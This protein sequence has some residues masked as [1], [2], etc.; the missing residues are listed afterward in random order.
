[1]GRSGSWAASHAMNIRKS[2][3]SSL[4]SPTS[5]RRAPSRPAS[6]TS[7]STTSAG[8][9]ARHTRPP[10]SGRRP[11][12]PRRGTRIC[13]MDAVCGR[14]APRVAIRCAFV[15]RVLRS[16]PACVTV[17][18][19]SESTPKGLSSRGRRSP[20]AWPRV[21]SLLA[22]AMARGLM[23]ADPDLGRFRA[24]GTLPSRWTFGRFDRR[25][26]ARTVP[27]TDEVVSRHVHPRPPPLLPIAPRRRVLPGR[28]SRTR[29]P[30]RSF[31]RR[32][33][34]AT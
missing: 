33:P 26:S 30:D 2:H 18:R 11:V 34:E 27:R 19:C 9:P 15:A 16:A 20:S 32:S 24:H 23:S 29:P 14:G 17:D 31:T 4:P 10:R 12:P 6:T 8:R 22:P 3:L 28:C 7:T 13:L 21:E 1:M 25:G 5:G